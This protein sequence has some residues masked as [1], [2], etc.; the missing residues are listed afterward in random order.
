M[1][2]EVFFL[3]LGSRFQFRYKALNQTALYQTLPHGITLIQTMP[4][5]TKASIAKSS[6]VHEE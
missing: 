6:C 4:T 2:D 5:K 1:Q 3:K